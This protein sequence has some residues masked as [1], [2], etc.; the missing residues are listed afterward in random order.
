MCIYSKGGKCVLLDVERC[1]GDIS[2]SFNTDK[3]MLVSRKER[4]YA[5]IRSLPAKQQ[6]ILS[7][8]YYGGR[9]PWE[10]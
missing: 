8:K 3:E 10:K 2:C 7:A 5:R 6:N 4:A 9:K 1:N